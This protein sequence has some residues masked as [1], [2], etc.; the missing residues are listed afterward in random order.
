MRLAVILHYSVKRGF[1]K[2]VSQS[3]KHTC[4]CNIRS[5]PWVNN[6]CY[7]SKKVTL[8]LRHLLLGFLSGISFFGLLNQLKIYVDKILKEK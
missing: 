2:L 7:R 4:Q 1:L 3:I 8:T 6:V 5:F